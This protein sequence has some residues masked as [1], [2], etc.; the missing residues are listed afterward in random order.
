MVLPI[1]P[2][3]LVRLAIRQ[4]ASGFDLVTV[5]NTGEGPFTI[6][7]VGIWFP[8][9]AMGYDFGPS[10][11]MSDEHPFPGYPVTIASGA[12]ATYPILIGNMVWALEQK[13]NQCV[14]FVYYAES[15]HNTRHASPQ[16]RIDAYLRAL[17]SNPLARHGPS[18]GGVFQA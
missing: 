7:S 8:A 5:T 11:L 2:G 15:D 1:P 18:D 6:H 4:I 13:R 12:A 16:V 3:E 10:D 14:D 9:L 17:E